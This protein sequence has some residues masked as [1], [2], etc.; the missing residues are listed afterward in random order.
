MAHR[1]E[2]GLPRVP[3]EGRGHS[4]G[5]LV[6]KVHCPSEPPAREHGKLNSSF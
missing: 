5:I 3:D 6:L 1:I 4:D 2:G